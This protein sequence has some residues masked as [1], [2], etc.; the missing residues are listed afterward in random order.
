MITSTRRPISPS[1]AKRP[2]RPD[3]GLLEVRYRA[4]GR[5]EVYVVHVG[6]GGIRHWLDTVRTAMMAAGYSLD[7]AKHLTYTEES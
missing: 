3:V 6:D 4:E 5:E 2:G 1:S 7:E